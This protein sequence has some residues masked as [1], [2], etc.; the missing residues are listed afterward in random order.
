MVREQLAKERAENIAAI[1]NP[2]PGSSGGVDQDKYAIEGNAWIRKAYPNINSITKMTFGLR[3]TGTPMGPTL[4][5][6]P[7]PMGLPSIDV[8]A[9]ASDSDKVGAPRAPT[10]QE[11]GQLLT[12]L[13]SIAGGL[14]ASFFMLAWGFRAWQCWTSR[15]DSKIL[16]AKEEALPSDPGVQM[17]EMDHA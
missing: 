14:V 6:A 1:T 9:W 16:L 10:P 5:P 8:A 15:D 17:A 13:G 4:G 2:T 3:A 11:A 12:L 7:P